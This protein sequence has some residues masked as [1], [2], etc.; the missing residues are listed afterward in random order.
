MKNFHP[1]LILTFITSIIATSCNNNTVPSIADDVTGTYIGSMNVASPSYQ[2]TS[3]VVTVT[4]V[5]S[6]RVRITP[7]DSHASA[8]EQDVMKPS[9][10]SI[11]CVVC[12]T[13]QLSFDLSHS[14]NTIAYN[15]S[16]SAEQFSGA[17]Q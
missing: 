5:S 10:T 14:P 6:T 9:S 13:N 8:W 2:N 3:Y 15:Y 17:K 11:T 7:Q 12:T 16:N 1:L 4:S